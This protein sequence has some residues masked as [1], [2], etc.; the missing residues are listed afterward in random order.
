MN[1]PLTN[2]CFPTE[3]A[4]GQW[5]FDLI[6]PSLADNTAW[7]NVAGVTFL[8]NANEPVKVQPIVQ[9]TDAE[10]NQGARAPADANGDF[11][12]FDVASQQTTAIEGLVQLPA[13]ATV[14]RVR[15]RVF[16]VPEQTAV[17]EGIIRVDAI[18]PVPAQ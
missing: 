3:T 6:S 9:Y 13:G 4:S 10:G 14:Q 12:F 17:S 15:I 1:V 7:Q 2:V 8:V 11:I 18:C 5:R 16:G